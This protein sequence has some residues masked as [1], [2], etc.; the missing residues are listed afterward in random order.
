MKRCSDVEPLFAPYVD[1]EADPREAADVGAHLDACPPCREQVEGER[2]ARAFVHDRRGSLCDAAPASLRARCAACAGL[3]GGARRWVPLSLAATIV[4]AVAGVFLYGSFD[5]GAR[6]FATQLTLD[7]VKCFA[8][9]SDPRGPADAAALSERWRRSHG[10]ALPVPPPRE[11]LE[12][13]GVRLCLSSEGRTAHIMYRHQGRPLSVFVAH[14][15]PP[16]G[17]RPRDLEVLGHQA[18]LWSEGDR[19]FAVVGRETP[20][21]LARVAEYVRSVSPVRSQ[22]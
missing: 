18:I 11:A 3:G 20:D 10:W 6:A 8:V 19:T 1:G 16:R 14:D 17:R 2:A 21:E 22:K 4:L 15:N 12:L 5:R 7:H 13:L 9:S